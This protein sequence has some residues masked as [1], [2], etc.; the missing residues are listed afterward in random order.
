MHQLKLLLLGFL[1]LFL[2][3]IFIRYLPSNIWNLGYFPN[4]V[5]LSVFVGMGLGFVVHHRISDQ[6][7]RKLFSSV[8]GLL[9]GLILFVIAFRPDIPG[10]TNWSGNLAGELY[11]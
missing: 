9:L 11:F 10:F 8:P 2:E 1:T 3:L 5:L 4:L 6:L 7:S